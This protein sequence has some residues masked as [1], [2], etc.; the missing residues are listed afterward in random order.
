MMKQA[1]LV[2]LVAIFSGSANAYVP[3]N[4]SKA[5]VASKPAFDLKKAVGASFTA[6]TIASNVITAPVADAVDFGAQYSPSAFGSSTVVAEKVTREGLYGS[7]EVDLVQEVDKAE[8]TFKSAKETKSK[9]GKYTALLAVLV[10]GSFII[11]MA[12]YFWYV[13]D[14]SSSDDFFAEEVPE[15]EPKKKGWF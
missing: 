11:P 3:S 7:Y 2:A 8:S 5:K 10:V 13:K 9:K 14:D 1:L 12:Q 4:P 15:P 6:L